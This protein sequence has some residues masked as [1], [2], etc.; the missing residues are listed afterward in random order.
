MATKKAGQKAGSKRKGEVGNP[1][2]LC[3][4]LNNPEIDQPVAG[5]YAAKAVLNLKKNGGHIDADELAKILKKLGTSEVGFVILN[6]PF[7]L[8]QS[9]AT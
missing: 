6:A 5:T 1:A 7:K 8:R 4:N 2:E 9:E 3:F